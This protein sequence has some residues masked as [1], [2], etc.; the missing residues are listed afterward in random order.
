MIKEN[1]QGLWKSTDGIAWELTK[2]SAEYLASLPSEATLPITKPTET[3]LLQAEIITLKSR[4]AKIE[5]VPI[6]KTALEPIIKDP[7]IIK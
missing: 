5:A 3:E 7:I 6:V 4:L 1:Y 2:P